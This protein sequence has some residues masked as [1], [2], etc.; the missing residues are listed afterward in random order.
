MTREEKAAKVRAEIK[1][2]R[3]QMADSGRVYRHSIDGSG[4]Y[5]GS[6]DLYGQ[7]A[8][9]DEDY[10]NYHSAERQMP[11]DYYYGR[12]RP[13]CSQP[14]LHGLDIDNYRLLSYLLIPSYQFFYPFSYDF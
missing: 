8:L 10:Y 11:R 5:H 6:D 13:N 7:S 12:L 1:R 4:L 2:R 9:T 14:S 3:Q